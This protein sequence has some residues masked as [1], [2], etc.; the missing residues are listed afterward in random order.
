MDAWWQS[1]VEGIFAVGEAAGTHGVYRPGGSALNAGQVG[2]KRAS[3]YI[4]MHRTGNWM[5]KEIRPEE[6]SFIEEIARNALRGSLD[7]NS[8][9]D[10]ARLRMSLHGSCL[11]N[12]KGLEKALAETESALDSFSLVHAEARTLWKLFEY[13][14]ALVSQKVYL[15]AM[16]DYASLNLGSRGSAVYSDDDGELQPPAMDDRFRHS[17]QK[18]EHPMIQMAELEKDG[19]VLISYRKPRPIPQE[20][21]AFEV[22][23]ARYRKDKCIY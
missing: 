10:E 18:D 6:T 22:V 7:L 4:A 12:R 11:R 23:W 21:E 20:E 5:K 13:R 9:Y 1:S 2:S 8:E 14:T 17:L 15:S 16:L 3:E 19:R